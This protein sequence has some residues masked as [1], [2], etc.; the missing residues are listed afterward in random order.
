MFLSSQMLALLE[1]QK[2]QGGTP[3]E[4]FQFPLLWTFGGQPT[5]AQLGQ[6]QLPAVTMTTT[7]SNSSAAPSPT[8]SNASTDSGVSGVSSL[9]GISFSGETH[10]LG[11]QRRPLSESLSA[12]GF[13]TPLTD[14]S[15][16]TMVKQ[17]QIQHQHILGQQQQLYQHYLEQQQRLMQQ[18]R[19]IDAETE[20][21]MQFRSILRTREIQSYNRAIFYHRNTCNKI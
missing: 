12:P 13:Q 6:I 18:V 7:T 17:F 1:Q 21:S 16:E 4:M 9:S 15:Y 5:A 11:P 8:P 20:G 14:S 19:P 10:S 3:P 2:H